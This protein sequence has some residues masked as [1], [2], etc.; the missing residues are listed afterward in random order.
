MRHSRAA[1]HWFY[2]SFSEHN[3][4]MCGN[5]ILQAWISDPD[6]RQFARELN[7]TWKILGRKMSPLVAANPDRYTLI[8]LPNPVVVP[9]GRFR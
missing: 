4:K 5:L 7:A 6:Y 1:F 2:S 3:P 9:G 8:P